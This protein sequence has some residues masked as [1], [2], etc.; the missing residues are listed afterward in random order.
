MLL[1][2]L[3]S[4]RLHTFLWAGGKGCQGQSQTLLNISIA[5]AYRPTVPRA[6]EEPQRY[7]R[8]T[9]RYEIWRGMTRPPTSASKRRTEDTRTVGPRLQAHFPGHRLWLW[10]WIG[11]P[12]LLS[13]NELFSVETKASEAAAAATKSSQR[14][15]IKSGTRRN[16]GFALGWF[17]TQALEKKKLLM[18][19]KCLILTQAEWSSGLRCQ[20]YHRWGELGSNLLSDTFPLITAVQHLNNWCIHQALFVSC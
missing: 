13:S 10:L 6:T 19:K 20:M 15:S 2:H 3:C 4:K 12:S 9:L 8:L 17:M 14:D 5:F 7:I 18:K 1:S 16:F 11:S